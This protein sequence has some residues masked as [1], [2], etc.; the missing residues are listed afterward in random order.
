MGFI[1]VTG[2]MPKVGTKLWSCTT[3]I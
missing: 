3:M 1:Y 2:F